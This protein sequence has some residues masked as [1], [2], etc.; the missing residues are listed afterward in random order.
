[1]KNDKI[2]KTQ[3]ALTYEQTMERMRAKDRKMK[4]VRILLRAVL[5]LVTFYSV[6]CNAMA[7]MGW[8]SSAQAG[9][10][11]PIHFVDYG[12]ILLFA[13][14]VLAAAV[15]LCLFGLSRTS[16]CLAVPSTI[17][18]FIVTQ[19]V[20]NYANEAGFYST[21][22][23]MPAGSVYQDAVFPTAIVCIL[24]IILSLMQ[25]FSMESV[26]KRR[27]KKQ[28]ENAPAPKIV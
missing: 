13:T 9:E 22:R 12:Y 28:R 7:S 4:I 2:K 10:N 14:G 17:V 1:M 5:L 19:I 3:H 11:W 21:L 20:V 15:I 16:M 8:I 23:D 6:F 24:L 27:E 25:Y 26:Q 18:C